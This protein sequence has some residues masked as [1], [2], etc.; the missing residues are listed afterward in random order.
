MR[1]KKFGIAKSGSRP[2]REQ[3]NEDIRKVDLSPILPSNCM[4]SYS[5]ILF[6]MKDD[7]S[8][9]MSTPNNTDG[10]AHLVC[11]LYADAVVKKLVLTAARVSSLVSMVN[12]AETHP[13]GRN[14]RYRR[15]RST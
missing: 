12:G 3:E 13:A 15:R 10:L 9:V 6:E 1:S 14:I 5:L 2:L 7:I 11:D 8:Y 4:S